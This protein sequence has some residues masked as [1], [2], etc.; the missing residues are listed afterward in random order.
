MS[1]NSFQ[2]KSELIVNGKKYYYYDIQIAAEKLG[3]NVN[4]LPFSM[5][6]LFEN[7]LRKE[8]GIN[9]TKDMIVNFMSWVKQGGKSSLELAYYPARVLMQDFTGVPCVVD[10]AAMRSFVM[11]AG[12]DVSKINPVIPTDLVIDH[13]VQVDYYG[14]PS[15]LSKNI[16][17]EM[18]RNIERY[19]LLKWAKEHFSNFRVVPPGMGICHQVNLEYLAKVVFRSPE[20]NGEVILYPDTLV[21]TDSH[22]TMINA[23]SVLGWGVGGIEAES[24]MLGQSLSLKQPEVIGVNLKNKP[25]CV[26][27]TDIVLTVT[28]MLRKK[29]VVEKFVEF[30]GEGL[31]YLSLADRATISNM[32]PEYGATCGFFPV[33]AETINYLKNTGRSNEEVAIVEAYT[34]KQNLY[35]DYYYTPKYTEVLDF[36]LATMRPSV[37]GP[38]RPQDRIEL[39]KV[40]T[41]LD[42]MMAENNKVIDP[43]NSD[44]LSDGSIVIAAITSCTNT[45]NPVLMI[46]AGLLAKNAALKGLKAKPFVKTSLSPGSQVVS[47]YLQKSGLQTYLDQVGFNVTGFGCMTCIGNSGPLKADIEKEIKNHNLIVASVLSGNRNFEGRIHNMVKA[48]YLC[49]P[50]L[51]VAY[52]LLGNIRLDIEKTPLGKDAKGNDIVLHDIWPQPEEVMN[53]IKQVVTKDLFV[54]KYKNIEQGTQ[55][56]QNIKIADT[57]IFSWRKNSHYIENPPYFELLKANTQFSAVKDVMEAYCLLMLGD[58][59]T[60]DHISPA[61]NIAINSPAAKYLLSKGVEK[62]QFNSYGARRG[63]HNVMMRGTFANIRI[64]NELLPD[65]TGPLSVHLPSG[66]VDSVYD[67]AM[68]YK[69]DNASL[70]IIAGKEYGTGSS[71]DWAAKGT[72]LLGVK[73][74][75]AESFERIHRSNLVGMGV[76][77]IEFING[78]SRKTLNLAG[79]EKYSIFN[80]NRAINGDKIVDIEIHYIDGTRKRTKGKLRI[81]TASEVE[82]YKAGGLLPFVLKK[83]AFEMDNN[84]HQTY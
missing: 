13:S 18:E 61:G 32:A 75:I 16:A 72:K 37:A 79:K 55:E 8:D 81:D 66:K 53:I 26:T 76:L 11:E 4:D 40:S 20:K 22:T 30:F 78:E 41:S 5:K 68:Q 23:L 27:A 10:L 65:V 73:A 59:I 50:P 84:P 77:P 28:E 69:H 6:V 64:K 21:G 67:I 44:K 15:A 36:D 49:S 19:E 46:M 2:S 52:S 71:R 42:S 54:T 25:D 3:F 31:K 57:K 60:T 1:S 51:V 7:L 43:V 38:K 47:E 17:L 74:V 14:S 62:S 12:G 29:G 56:W 24:A 58:S 34:K 80:V 48:N 70:I 33:D 39:S 45:S 35:Y 63:S 82:F 83:L 9:V